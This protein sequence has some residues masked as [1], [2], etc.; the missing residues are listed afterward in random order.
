M[1]PE[2]VKNQ[3]QKRNKEFFVDM[4]GRWVVLYSSAVESG[5]L[6]EGSC[7]RRERILKTIQ[8]EQKQRQ[9]ELNLDDCEEQEIK[10]GLNTRV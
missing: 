7:R 1:A 8:E 5:P 3:K 2:I 6:K 9:N 4:K 10:E